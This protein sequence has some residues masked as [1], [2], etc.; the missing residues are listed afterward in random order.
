V[1]VRA[2]PTP[3]SPLLANVFLHDVLDTWFETV[4][5]A[6]CRGHVVLYRYADDVRRS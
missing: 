6:H 2:V 1:T 4:V 5:R 3:F